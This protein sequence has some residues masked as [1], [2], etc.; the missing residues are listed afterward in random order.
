MAAT[1]SLAGLVSA[2]GRQDPSRYYAWLHAEAVK[3]A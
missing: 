1:V 3:A 2:E